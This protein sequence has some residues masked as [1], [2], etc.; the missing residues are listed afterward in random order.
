MQGHYNTDTNKRENKSSK[1][2]KNNTSKYEGKEG[3]DHRN[4]KDLPQINNRKGTKSNGNS[5]LGT[6]IN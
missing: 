4:K 2:Q 6:D 1:V 5:Y 3:T